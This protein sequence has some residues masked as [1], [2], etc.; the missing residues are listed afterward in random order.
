[1]TPELKYEE[2]MLDGIKRY[3][4]TGGETWLGHFTAAVINNDLKSAVA[5]ADAYNIE[6]IPV[7]VHWLF[8]NAPSSSWGFPTASR[9]WKGMEYWEPEMEADSKAI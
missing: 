7:Y 5:H 4:K 2:L 6:L 8:N 3:I 1:M 9:D